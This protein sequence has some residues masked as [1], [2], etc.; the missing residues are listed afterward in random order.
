MSNK[1]AILLTAD[2][3]VSTNK[4]TTPTPMMTVSLRFCLLKIAIKKDLK[5]FLTNNLDH[6]IPTM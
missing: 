4:N 1:D 5:K 6:N 2:K 3:L